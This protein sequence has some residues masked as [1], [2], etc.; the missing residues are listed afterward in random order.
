[1]KRLFNDI[2]Q[3]KQEMLQ[4]QIKIIRKEY[5]RG[6]KINTSFLV[7]HLIFIK[8][9]SLRQNNY[10]YSMND[11]IGLSSIFSSSPFYEGNI[12]AETL[13]SVD[14]I[15]KEDVLFLINS[16]HKIMLN[17]LQLISDEFK[18]NQTHLLMLSHIEYDKRLLHY[19]YNEYKLNN[20]TTFLINY[21]KKEL[22][23]YLLIDAKSFTVELNKL[24]KSNII[25]NQ[26]KLYTILDI[27]LVEK[28]IQK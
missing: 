8:R 14:L 26:N 12:Y 4:K 5:L 20:A 22:A 21:K 13:T 27:A 11:I 17:L 9:G 24:I 18:K 23:Q 1:M 15:T 7:S 28:I 6:D 2:G 10:I 25:S 19:F 16:D 3:N